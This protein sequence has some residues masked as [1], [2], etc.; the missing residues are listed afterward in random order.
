MGNCTVT[1]RKMATPQAVPAGQSVVAD[2]ALSTSYATGGDTIPLASLGLPNGVDF[3]D[4]SGGATTPG[5]HAV[6]VVHGA[7]PGTAPK[8]RVRDVA[9]GTELAN[10]SNNSGQTVRVMAYALPFP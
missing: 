5:G 4:V 1:I 2:I 7:T 8:L 9:A 3:I 10:A 6:E